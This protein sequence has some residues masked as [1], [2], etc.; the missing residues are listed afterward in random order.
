[1][2]ISVKK[3]GKIG[4]TLKT[5]AARQGSPV[6]DRFLFELYTYAH[7]PVFQNIDEEDISTVVQEVGRR[8]LQEKNALNAETV[9]QTLQH[10]CNPEDAWDL[11]YQ[12][13]VNVLQSR[14]PAAAAQIQTTAE[15]LHKALAKAASIPGKATDR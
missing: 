13:A 6:D 7:H 11:C 3:L 8:A 5:Q 10:I 12:A 15:A 2:A 9:K 1:M 4:A 14:S